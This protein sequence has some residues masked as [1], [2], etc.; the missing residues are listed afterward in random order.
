MI[1]TINILLLLFSL[2]SLQSFYINPITF[3]RKTI[4]HVDSRLK[5]LTTHSFAQMKMNIDDSNISEQTKYDLQ[6]YVIGVPSDFSKSIPK[7][8]RV[9][10]KE[11]AVWKGND[12]FFRA[13]QNEC[14]HKGA[15]L[16]GGKIINDKIIC[17]YH[18]YEFAK[19]G[20]LLKVPGICFNH[21]SIHD[22][23]SY[24]VVEKNGWVY[25]NTYERNSE[26]RDIMFHENIY[27]EPEACSNFTVVHLK[28]NFN[29]YSRVL[30][31]NS[32]DVMHIG[33]VHTFG[34][35][36][37]PAPT[38]EKP[39]HKINDYHYKTIYNYESGGDSM[40]RRIFGVKKLIIENE[41]I[42]PHTTVARV[43]FGDFVS[44]VITFALP[45]GDNKSI[46][47]VKTYRNFWINSIG[48]MVT[49]NMMFDTMNQ[50]KEVVENINPSCMDGKFNIKY[51]KL[52]NVYKT[53]YRR[54]IHKID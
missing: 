38:F 45:V 9:W 31:E 33:F 23:S 17:P 2:Q 4:K 32:L 39:P 29:C 30:S 27:N 50:D 3:I 22:I 52:Q 7:K 5:P 53:F 42:L 40:A 41:F 44:T 13:T 51:D 49:Y 12:G 15:S 18:G 46:L 43:I 1:F 25:L 11:Y 54:F 26:T 20:T 8:V 16:S 36:I 28:L 35:R 14:S 10:N 34:N 24:P 47:Y 48:D 37:K 6:W 21:T 19:N